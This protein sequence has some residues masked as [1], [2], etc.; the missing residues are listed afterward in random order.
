[1][2]QT[3]I[4]RLHDT[5]MNSISSSLPQGSHEIARRMCTITAFRAPKSVTALCQLHVWMKYRFL[6]LCL[7]KSRFGAGTGANSHWYDLFQYDN[8]WWHHVNDY[9]AMTVN[10]GEIV[11]VQKS[12]RDQVNTP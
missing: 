3:A 8:L 10:R 12:L 7:S 5:G 4:T 1:M 11:L 6:L 9:R 2:K